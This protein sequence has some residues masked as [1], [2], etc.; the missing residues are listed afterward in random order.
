MKQHIPDL[1]RVRAKQKYQLQFCVF[2]NCPR[3]SSTLGHEDTCPQIHLLPQIQKLADRSDA[4][5]E[6]PKC[7]EIQ[8]I[9]GETF[10]APRPPN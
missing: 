10:S 1:L 3:G 5:S 8:I 9:A 2:L 7:S 4:I 6:V